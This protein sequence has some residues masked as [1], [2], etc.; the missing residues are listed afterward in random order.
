MKNYVLPL[1]VIALATA[2]Y[3][4]KPKGM[5]ESTLPDDKAH[6]ET[7][8]KSTETQEVPAVSVEGSAVPVK[9]GVD[10]TAVARKQIVDLLSLNRQSEN[11]PELDDQVTALRNKLNQM[12]NKTEVL[13]SY[14]QELRDKNAAPYDRAEVL[15]LFSPNAP[16]SRL[17]E[18]ALQESTTLS[19]EPVLNLEDANTQEEMNEALS[20][21]AEWIPTLVA[22]EVFIKNCGDYSSCR[23]GIDAVMGRHRNRNIRS[24]LIE[25]VAM[26]FPEEAH[27]M[28]P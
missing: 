27:Q 4:L 13:W 22:F 26:R 9:E 16:D 20:T 1:A 11:K 2:M 6:Q 14:Y 12:P 21:K 19:T 17:A 15:D 28:N 10:T 25:V 8:S 23:P 7:L 3:L 5:I 18:V 24:N